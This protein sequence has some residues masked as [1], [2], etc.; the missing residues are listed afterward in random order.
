MVRFPCKS[1]VTP[2]QLRLIVYLR[3]L[4][5]INGL[6]SSWFRT[7]P[8]FHLAGTEHVKDREV[9]LSLFRK[10]YGSLQRFILWEDCLV[11]QDRVCSA[12][13]FCL[14]P[15]W[16]AQH[17]SCLWSVL[18]TLRLLQPSERSR[19]YPEIYQGGNM[20]W[21]LHLGLSKRKQIIFWL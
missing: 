11:H 21:V 1:N 17:P 7:H 5:Q 19:K 8:Y 16:E 4:L 2:P 15:L 13:A 14:R 12:E 10:F 18:L 9:G 6:M 20:F 3:L